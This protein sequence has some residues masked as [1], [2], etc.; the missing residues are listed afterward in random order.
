MKAFDPVLR[1]DGFSDRT[2]DLCV[3]A[4]KLM[5]DLVPI[6]AEIQVLGGERAVFVDPASRRIANLAAHPLQRYGAEGQPSERPRS[7]VHD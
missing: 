3:S 2:V 1:R 4:R 6:G 7:D 5:R